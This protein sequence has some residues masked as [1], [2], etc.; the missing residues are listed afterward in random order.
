METVVLKVFRFNP[1]KDRVPYYQDYEVP[2]EGT[3]LNALLY[4]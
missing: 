4:I 3:L 2:V 1:E